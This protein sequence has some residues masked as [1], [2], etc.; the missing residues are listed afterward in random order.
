MEIQTKVPE[1]RQMTCDEYY[2][3]RKRAV[4]IRPMTLTALISIKY[5]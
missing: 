4:K 2:Y 5:Q 3:Y 1:H